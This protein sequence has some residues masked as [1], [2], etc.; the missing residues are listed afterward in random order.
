MPWKN[1]L[2]KKNTYKWS[3]DISANYY[4]LNN[5]PTTAGQHT[6]DIGSG[7]HHAVTQS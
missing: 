5:L 3:Q 4:G 6:M 1:R 2:C 7:A